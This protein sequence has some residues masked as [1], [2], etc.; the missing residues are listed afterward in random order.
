MSPLTSISLTSQAV[1]DMIVA[2]DATTLERLPAADGLLQGTAGAQPVY[3]QSPSVTNLTV[4]GTISGAGAPVL[5]DNTPA[6][7]SRLWRLGRWHRLLPRRPRTPGH[8]PA[9][10]RRLRAAQL[11]R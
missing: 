7:L 4:S 10:P 9:Y 8:R 1:G 3:T 2:R 11:V 5:S 6:A